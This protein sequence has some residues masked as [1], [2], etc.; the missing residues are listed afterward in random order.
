M[1]YTEEKKRQLINEYAIAQSRGDEDRCEAL[2]VELY[3]AYGWCGTPYF[4]DR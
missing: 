2:A 3:E 4:T 1:F